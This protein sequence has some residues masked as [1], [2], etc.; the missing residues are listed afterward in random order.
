MRK[1]LIII[2]ELLIVTAAISIANYIQPHISFIPKSIIHLP[3][4]DYSEGDFY[5]IFLYFLLIHALALL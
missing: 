3:D 4:V 5:T 2:I 1:I